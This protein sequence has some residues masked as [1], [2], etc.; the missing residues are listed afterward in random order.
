MHAGM[1]VLMLMLM[2]MPMPMPM[3]IPIPILMP[4]LMLVV[5]IATPDGNTQQPLPG[6][7]SGACTSRIAR[8]AIA[9]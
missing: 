7:S 6:G 5:V 8:A 9:L 3:L 4:A 1:P 2:L